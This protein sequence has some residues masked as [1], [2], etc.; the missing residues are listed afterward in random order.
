MR[1]DSDAKKRSIRLTIPQINNTAATGAEEL[2][3][4]AVVRPILKFQHDLLVAHFVRYTRKKKLDFSALDSLQQKALVHEV[5][6]HDTNYKTELRGIVL[7]HFTTGEF[8]TYAGMASE[9]N[10][11]MMKMIEERLVSVIHKS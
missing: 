9:I 6:Q 1:K 10:K 11:R 7:G 5:F 8:E 2:F 4:N 3:Q